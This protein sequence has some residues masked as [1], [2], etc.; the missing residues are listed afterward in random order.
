MTDD[1]DSDSDSLTAPSSRVSPDVPRAHTTLHSAAHALRLA[2]SALPKLSPLTPQP[3]IIELHLPR[4]TP[5]AI[6]RL[7][8]A[9]RQKVES[10]LDEVRSI[11]GVEVSLGP[12]RSE[13]ELNRRPI[14][15]C[16]SPVAFQPTQNVVLDLSLLIA[17]LS[18]ISHMPLPPATDGPEGVFLP[19]VRQYR[20]DGSL[21][22]E[23][24]RKQAML[25]GSENAKAL[26]VQLGIEMAHPLVDEL[27]D[28]LALALPT[29]AFPP[30]SC[31]T[32]Q[33]SDDASGEV[34]CWATQESA[35]R[36]QAIVRKLASPSELLRAQ[37][38]WAVPGESPSEREARTTAWWAGS[39]ANFS[40]S[41]ADAGLTKFHRALADVRLLP[42]SRASDPFNLA[43]LEGPKRSWTADANQRPFVELHHLLT[44][45]LRPPNQSEGA[46]PKLPPSLTPHTVRTLLAASSRGWTVLTTNRASLARLWKYI[47]E[48]GVDPSL[49]S[50]TAVASESISEDGARAQVARQGLAV[51]WLLEPRSL[52][53][54]MRV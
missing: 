9:H 12:A 33:V 28:G 26:T 47:E 13:E 10:V 44:H 29:T 11:P 32:S 39:R 48:A 2:S 34:I 42:A 51:A 41:S 16:Y 24:E 40:S 46:L 43:P 49:G 37:M 5:K 4:F 38:I 31:S 1:S 35:D 7:P 22:S 30:F 45:L 17:L 21:R 52:A 20:K 19:L 36:L 15:P 14:F 25:G 18:H 6:D 54:S 3:E 53:E 50:A 23:A 27:V 8:D